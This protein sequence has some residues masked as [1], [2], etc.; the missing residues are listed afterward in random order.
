V[1][2]LFPPEEVE[3]GRRYHRPRYLSSVV[4]FAVSVAALALLAFTD[5]G[6][7]LLPEW[8][9]WAQ[10]LVYPVI[11][12][13]VLALVQLPVSYWRGYVH[14]RR[15]EL[16]TQTPRGWFVDRVKSFLVAVVISTGLYLGFVSLARATDAWP[17]I[18]APLAA[19]VV[20][21]LSFIA[22]VVLEPIFNKF[23]PLGDEQLADDL[24][25][26]SVQAGVPVRD[27]LVADASRRTTKS[28]A[29]VS[30]FGATRRVVVFDTMLDHSKPAEL[31]AVL[32]H[33][34]AHRRYRD[35]LTLTLL[36]VAAAVGAVLLL[37]AILGSDAR[38]PRNFP[39]VLLVLQLVQPPLS[40]LV[41]A[42]ARRAEFRADRFALLVTRDPAA[43]ESAF[44]GLVETNV[45]DL[46]PPR[47]VYYLTYTHPTVPER[48]EAIR[49]T[50]TVEGLPG[51]EAA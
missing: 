39:L 15:W 23:K 5:L 19:V 49:R 1:G 25:A 6:D 4:D 45:A 14:E 28:N 7:A 27:V 13:G 37:W 30:G 8:D 24:R 44:R 16:T 51:E 29:Y 41:A 17:L 20:V 43:L 9:W 40:A 36:G 31:R 50:A 18:A 21:F 3:R 33:E 35:V 48:L 12:L 38:D 46:D 2:E 47:L 11:V 32:A 10:A 26:L 22:P 34:L 42:I